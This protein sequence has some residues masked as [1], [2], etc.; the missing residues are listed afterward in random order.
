MYQKLPIGT[1]VNVVT[2]LLG[3]LIGVW[4]EQSFPTNIK[5][6]AF[7]AIGLI[8]LL[9]GIQ[10]SLKLPEGYLLLAIIS[11]VLGGI[12]GEIMHLDTL[13]NG[14]AENLKTTLDIDDVQFTEGLITA[15]LLFS[16][17][18]MVIVGAIEEGVK[19]D[20]TLLLVKSML[21]GVSSIVFASTYGIG[22]LFSIFPVLLIQGGI[23]LLA[24]RMQY[25]FT[26][27]IIAQLSAVGGLLIIAIGI[28]ILELGKINIEN[29]L[30]GLLLVV[31]L[32]WGYD[33]F[34]HFLT[35]RNSNKHERNN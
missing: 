35:K 9:I 12:V 14:L 7:Q 1:L 27:T 23:T 19:G 17:G 6:I 10:M 34:Q 18:S 28:N 21:D 26:E 25:F 2:I 16:I 4:L 31:I 32:T 15:S 8:S 30:P 13:L 11:M 24:R 29:L 20:R 3:S 22:I 5:A 33:K